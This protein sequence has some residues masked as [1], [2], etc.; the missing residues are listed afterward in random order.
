MKSWWSDAW[1]LFVF[2]SWSCFATQ[3]LFKIIYACSVNEGL[4]VVGMG[5]KF[6]SWINI[7]YKLGSRDLAYLTNLCLTKAKST[8]TKNM[9]IF[10]CI[11]WIYFILLNKI[12]LQT[13]YQL[14]INCTLSPLC[15]CY[16][17]ECSVLLDTRFPFSFLGAT[18]ALHDPQSL[19]AELMLP[20][21]WHKYLS[22][23]IFTLVTQSSKY[24]GLFF[25]PSTSRQNKSLHPE[26]CAGLPTV[27][28]VPLVSS[29][30]CPYTA[31]A[32]HKFC[33][34]SD[35]KGWEPFEA[36]SL[37]PAC[38]RNSHSGKC[39]FS[40]QEGSRWSCQAEH[41]WGC[42]SLRELCCAPCLP[43]PRILLL[44]LLLSGP[45]NL[46]I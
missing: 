23:A 21:S 18:Y 24:C 37:L 8:E 33:F 40:L 44:L 9:F 27:S 28:S 3:R 4:S 14:F 35:F 22:Q 16:L 31:E 20:C 26:I 39:L 11:Y 42:R 5:L 41:A 34:P 6:S 36:G 32:S 17:K 1:G 43:M 45:G 46:C 29:R 7:W 30:G 13:V 10:P 19:Q 38:F 25:L 12:L 15:F 2:F